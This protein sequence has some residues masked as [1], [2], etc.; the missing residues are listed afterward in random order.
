M[1]LDKVRAEITE[2]DTGIIRLIAR[3]QELAG[4]IA[5]I[6]IGSRI[7]VR[8]EKRAAKVLDLASETAAEHNI[9]P[10]SVRKIF[11]ILIAMSE[12]LQKERS[13]EDFRL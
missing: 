13:G 11:E 12:D 6:K 4:Q 3:R 8:D 1:S 7:P 9:D 10:V 2:V 5:K